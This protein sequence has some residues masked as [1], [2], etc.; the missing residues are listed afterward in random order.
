MSLEKTL[1]FMSCLLVIIVKVTTVTDNN[2]SSV[3]AEANLT[4]NKAIPIIT[5]QVVDIMYG[6]VE[7]LNITST[8]PGT[9]N[10]ML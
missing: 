3:S 5:I 2:H 1:M 7:V 4:I 10:V 9:V 8:A 6:E